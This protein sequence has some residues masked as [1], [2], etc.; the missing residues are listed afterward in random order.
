MFRHAVR[1]DFFLSPINSL[2]TLLDYVKI[3]HHKTENM[4]FCSRIETILAMYGSHKRVIPWQL[5]G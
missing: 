2:K 3:H 1:K 4:F 5:T